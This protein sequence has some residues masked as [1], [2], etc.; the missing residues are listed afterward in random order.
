MFLA[1]VSG[2]IHAGLAACGSAIGIGLVGAKATEAIGR[3]PG[4]TTTI[5]TYAIV[6]IALSES[7][8]FLAWLL[9]H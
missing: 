1:E 8:F 2:S 3:N 9:V 4:A 6:F 7:I 5:V